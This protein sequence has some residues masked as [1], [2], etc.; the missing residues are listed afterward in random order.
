MVLKGSVSC[1]RQSAFLAQASITWQGFTHSSSMQ[2]NWLSHWESVRQ[3]GSI[4][5]GTVKYQWMKNETN[6]IMGQKI[7]ICLKRKAYFLCRLCHMDLQ[8]N[9]AHKYIFLC[10]FW[11]GNRHALRTRRGQHT[12]HS[13]ISM[14]L[15]NQG[16]WYTQVFCRIH[17]DC[18]CSQADKCKMPDDSEQH[19]GHLFHSAHRCMDLDILYWCMLE[20]EGIH[21][22][23]YNQ[24]KN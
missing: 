14:L 9:Q 23:S 21:C 4:I 20:W 8:Y 22:H 7:P 1:T 15:G 13:H 11:L 6:N 17:R 24:L 10:D 19:I 3:S 5:L 16:P 18:P 12:F 2:A